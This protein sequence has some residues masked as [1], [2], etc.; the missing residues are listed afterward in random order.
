MPKETSKRERMTRN[1]RTE[2]GKAVYRKRCQTVEPVFGQIKS[3]MGFDRFLR[4]GLKAVPS[5]WLLICACCNL[6]KLHRFAFS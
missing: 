1:L 3:A 4:R 5:E 2:L 6:L